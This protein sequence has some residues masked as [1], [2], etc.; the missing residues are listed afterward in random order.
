MQSLVCKRNLSVE[1]EISQ[2]FGCEPDIERSHDLSR[3]ISWCY[4]SKHLKYELM[5]DRNAKTVSVSGDY[6]HPF[7]DRS[8]Y[9]ICLLYDRMAIE[10]E[11]EIYRDQKILVFRKDYEG[12]KNFKCLMIM[13]WDDGE[14][15]VWPNIYDAYKSIMESCEDAN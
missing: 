6:I 8:L 1:D 2:F 14:L 13:R 7:S 11:P 9:E 5:L 3:H 4:E 15:S 10:T 12:E